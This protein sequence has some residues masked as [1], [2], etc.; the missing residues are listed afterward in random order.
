VAA[1]AINNLGAFIQDISQNLPDRRAAPKSGSVPYFLSYFWQIQDPQRY[2]VYYTSMLDVLRDRN[3]WSP[4]SDLGL[5]YG[6]FYRLNHELI[7]LFSKEAG[8]KLTLYDVEHAFWFA[9]Q[10]EASDSGETVVDK[11]K[12]DKT[13]PLPPPALPDSYFPPI[14]AILPRLACN[15]PGIAALCQA[16]GISIE[17]VF[18]NRLG[19]LFQMLGY[20]TTTLGQGH[21]RVPDGIAVCRE[22]HYAIVY[23]AKVRQNGYLMGADDRAIREYITANT[24]RLRKDGIRSIY[25]MIVSSSFAGDHDHAIRSL[26][27]ETGASEILLV[28][29]DALLGLLEARLRDPFLTLG[30]EGI[31]RLFAASGLLTL[32]DISEF[33]GL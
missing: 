32:S 6:E 7:D 27:M 10:P 31:Q 28:E 24:N 12:S 8:R 9:A 29:V 1:K 3:L 20:E 21:G 30:P 23:D 4:P 33:R 11:P 15:D 14:V 5:A 16:Q 22:F 13:T 17:K 26:K 19:I 25:F 18:E 2:P